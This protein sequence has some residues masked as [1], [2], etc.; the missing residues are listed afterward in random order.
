VLATIAEV[1]IKTTTKSIAVVAQS[2]SRAVASFGRTMS[3]QDIHSRGTFLERAIGTTIAN[4]TFAS[5][6]LFGIPGRGIGGTKFA[7]QIFEAHA[8]TASIAVIGAGGTF[9][10]LSTVT[11]K[12]LAV[13]LLS[14]AVALVGAFSERMG[15]VHGHDVS[16]PRVS[17]GT[18]T[19]RAVVSGPRVVA[20]CTFVACALVYA[21]RSERKRNE[22][23]KRSVRSMPNRTSATQP[24]HS[25]IIL[26][27]SHR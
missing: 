13:P 23:K 21:P 6:V 11:G 19:K 12:A 26:V 3:T 9:T 18:S 1:S 7:G 14:I 2:T 24:W 16:H 8:D 4:V 22:K 20:I 10:C 17:L 27:H 25:A 5:H 15:V